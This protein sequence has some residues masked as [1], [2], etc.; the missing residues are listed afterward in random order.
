[1]RST[2][3]NLSGIE[4]NRLEELLSTLIRRCVKGHWKLIAGVNLGNFVNCTT[5]IL[6]PRFS[7]AVLL[8]V[9]VEVVPVQ[10]VI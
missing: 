7:D 8:E 9:M 5:F 10:D 3:V 1:M 4:S 2:V 6:T